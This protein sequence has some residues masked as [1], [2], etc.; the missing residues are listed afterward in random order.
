MTRDA[1]KWKRLKP[2]TVTET[3]VE[4]IDIS[5]EQNGQERRQQELKQGTAVRQ[6]PLQKPLKRT[7]LASSHKIEHLEIHGIE[8]NQ[9]NF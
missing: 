3:Y 4:D 9:D 7:P 2:Q 1:Q 8:R 5:R 6:I